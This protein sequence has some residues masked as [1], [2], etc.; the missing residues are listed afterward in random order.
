MWFDRLQ[1]ASVPSK[2]TNKLCKHTHHSNRSVA[3]EIFAN[4]TYFVDTPR[5]CYAP[6]KT[7]HEFQAPLRENVQT[8]L[9]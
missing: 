6:L 2:R 9:T 7:F 1:I 5:I 8:D 3:A 4:G